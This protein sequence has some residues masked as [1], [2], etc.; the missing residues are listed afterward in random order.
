MSSHLSQLQLDD[1]LVVHDERIHVFDDVG[2]IQR[3]QQLHLQRSQS[4]QTQ[5]AQ[6]C[7][8]QRPGGCLAVHASTWPPC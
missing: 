1:E 7:S 3:L 6:L 2:M 8:L 5:L 4:Q